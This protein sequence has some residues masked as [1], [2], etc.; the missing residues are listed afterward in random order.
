MIDRLEA[1]ESAIDLSIEK[2]QDIVDALEK[3]VDIDQYDWTLELGASNCA[4][5]HQY[6]DDDDCCACPIY[7]TTGKECEDTPY[8]EWSDAEGERDLIAM[9]EAAKEELAFL[10]MVKE[11]SED[12][13]T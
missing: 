7:E 3:A 1:G 10:R 5:C 8:R 13:E 11:K 12:G 4:L 9:R 6:T 2:W